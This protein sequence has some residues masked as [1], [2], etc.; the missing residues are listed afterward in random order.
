MAGYPN[1]SNRILAQLEARRGARTHHEIA[2]HF[3]QTNTK[4]VM[5]MTTNMRCDGH[6]DEMNDC[7]RARKRSGG[8]DQKTKR[9]RG[10]RW[11]Q[12]GQENYTYIRLVRLGA[13]QINNDYDD[14]EHD[15]AIGSLFWSGTKLHVQVLLTS[16]GLLQRQKN[17]M[18]QSSR[19]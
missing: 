3:G 12:K 13:H 4:S 2:S 6:G 18:I 19:P 8:G 1:L 5:I 15:V 14:D 11:N 16:T 17:T 9:T 10:A 7:R